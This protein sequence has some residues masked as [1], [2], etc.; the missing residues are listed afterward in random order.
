MSDTKRLSP[1]NC[2]L[3][4]MALPI[5]GWIAVAFGIGLLGPSAALAGDRSQ[6]GIEER[7]E[8]QRAIEEV[9]WRNRTWPDQNPQPKPPLDAV[10]PDE[11][12]RAK[13]ESYLKKSNALERWWG[14]PITAEQLQAE[15][16]RMSRQSRDPRMLRELFE[17]LGND[18]FVI[19]ETLGRPL[20]AD[21]LIRNW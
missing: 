19:A 4:T 8:A 9:Y 7:V 15:L 16:D 1:L 21:R 6:L 13:V 5:V 18:S 14:R 12:L 3:R 2:A 10:M 17:A 20:L 11:A